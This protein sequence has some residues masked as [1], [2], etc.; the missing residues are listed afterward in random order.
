MLNLSNLSKIIINNVQNVIVGKEH[1]IKLLLISLLCNGHVL[2]E[3]VPGTGKTTLVKSFAI[4]L[5][6]D[7]KRI[8]FTPDLLPSDITGIK[9]FNMKKSEFEFIK[10]PAFS[11]IIL[12]DEINRATPKTQSGLLECMEEKQITIDG[13]THI[14]PL[15][16]MVIATQN[17]IENMGVFPLPEAQL[18]RFLIKINMNYPSHEEG[19]GILSRFDK[20]NPIKELT[21]VASKEDIIAAQNDVNDVFVNK[22]LY[23]YII[24]IA[25]STRHTEN[26]ILGLSPRACISLLKVA[27]GYAAVNG[28]GY[29]LPDDIKAVA[30][31]VLAHRLVLKTSL[32]LKI[33]AAADIIKEIIDSVPV[34]TEDIDN[35]KL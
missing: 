11:N 29:L 28:R 22:D 6:C 9:Y 1:E 7:F 2:I 4:S 16:F 19:I 21:F 23:D 31:N 20:N 14:L 27:K 30:V 17:P 25:E 32:T 5:G 33:N 10:G 15:P 3:D 35:Y 13:E 8:Q 12:A 18:D 24:N 34:P 26:I